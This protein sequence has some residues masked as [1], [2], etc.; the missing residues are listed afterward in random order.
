MGETIHIG[1]KT[2]ILNGGKCLPGAPESWD[3]AKEWETDSNEDKV[4]GE[5]KWKFDCGFKLDFDGGIVKTSSRFY[6]PSEFYGPKWSGS[7]W[8]AIPTSTDKFHTEKE[9]EAE[10]LDELKE[11]VESYVKKIS[12]H[13]NLTLGT[14]IS[15]IE[16]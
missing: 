12:D 10:S 11:K 4:Y 13:I 14:F 8:I 2:I 7:L 6:P 1:N 15:N 5:P 9:F 3:A 16:S